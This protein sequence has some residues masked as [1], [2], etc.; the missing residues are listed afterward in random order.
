MMTDRNDGI[1]PAGGRRGLLTGPIPPEA[2]L[3][4]TG[5]DEDLRAAAV[6][7]SEHRRRED[8]ARRAVV[9]GAMR[10]GGRGS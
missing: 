4:A 8:L 5:R 1:Y 6:F 7:A 10:D 9:Y 3:A 2:E